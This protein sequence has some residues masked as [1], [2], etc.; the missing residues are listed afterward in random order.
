VVGTRSVDD[1]DI[2]LR[3]RVP[4]W[5]PEKGTRAASLHAVNLAS[6]VICHTLYLHYGIAPAHSPTHLW[7][8]ALFINNRSAS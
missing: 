1:L 6:Y 3:V 2:R 7:V 4:E 5:C 8:S